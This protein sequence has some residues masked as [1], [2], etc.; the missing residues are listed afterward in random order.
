MLPPE[1][2]PL[3]GNL[4]Q[5]GKEQEELFRKLWEICFLHTAFVNKNNAEIMD[6]LIPQ[7]DAVYTV[8]IPG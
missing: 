8:R 6:V 1:G 4:W 7:G 3:E 2:S 5:L